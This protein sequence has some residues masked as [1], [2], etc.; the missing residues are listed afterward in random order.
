MTMANNGYRPSRKQK[1][2]AAA[3]IGACL[4]ATALDG[5]SL[6]G[7]ED[8]SSPS[9]DHM[10]RSLL[11]KFPEESRKVLEELE[12]QRKEER[13][14]RKQLSSSPEQ[15]EQEFPMEDG[16]AVD[17]SIYPWAHGNLRPVAR[18]PEPE[19][20]TA[21]FWH[22]PKSG[23]STAKAI[24]R[25]M[26]K[27][28]DIESQPASILRAEKDGLVASGKVDVIFSSFPNMAAEHLFD[29]V[30]KGRMLAMFRHPVDRLVSKFYYLQIATWEKTYRPEW[31]NIDILDWIK[32]ANM[33]ND[34]MVK[35]LAGKLQRDTATETDLQRAKT[36][37]KRRFVV[38]L[39]Q[40]MEESTRRFNTV[41]G[42]DEE[43]K[44]A[45]RC[46]DRYFGKGDKKQNTNSHPKVEKGSPAWDLLAQ[47]NS[48]D[49][50]LYEYVLELFEEQR[51]IIG[52]YATAAA[53]GSEV[54]AEE[55]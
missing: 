49:I 7:R 10:R 29:P 35:K 32:G 51:D 24:Y 4:I 44:T 26:G 39:M 45:R 33:D 6:L 14:Q 5:L 2:I 17:D 40:H 9:P 22:I 52:S 1:S 34:H 21:M 19:R 3:I 46:M 37:I 13:G 31:K 27:N 18:A 50:R 47:K 15:R 8:E 11:Q 41:I 36:T 30:H 23:G 53:S 43:E 12:Q 55:E 16:A 42:I 48:L 25:C 54:V 20:E 38:G 28:I